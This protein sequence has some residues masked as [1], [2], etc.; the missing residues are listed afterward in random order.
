MIEKRKDIG[1]NDR[2]NL[3]QL[4]LESMSDEDF[5]EV[6]VQ[7]VFLFSRDFPASFEKSDDT[8]VEAPLIRKS[9]KHEV[10]SNIFL[11]SE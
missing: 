8:K 6:F 10:A 3:L 7:F 4:M 5:I 1:H 9:T 11:F 2:T